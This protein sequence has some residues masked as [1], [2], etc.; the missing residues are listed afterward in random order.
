MEGVEEEGVGALEGEQPPLV[1]QDGILVVGSNLV[2]GEESQ[3][4][5]CLPLQATIRVSRFISKHG[6]KSLYDVGIVPTRYQH[7][8]VCTYSCRSLM[9]LFQSFGW[10]WLAW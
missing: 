2:A 6:M 9:I 10:H 4:P 1:A 5:T 8:A 7:K 3:S